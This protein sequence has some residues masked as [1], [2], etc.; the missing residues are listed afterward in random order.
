MV[1]T[2]V[3]G[4]RFGVIG[5][6]RVGQVTAKRARGFDMDVHYYNRSVW[7]RPAKLARRIMTPWTAC[8]RM[9]T[10]SPSIVLLPRKPK[11]W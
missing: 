8:C 10:C 4:K 7:T 2:Q 6:G 5:M 11:A 1:G 3:T 9:R